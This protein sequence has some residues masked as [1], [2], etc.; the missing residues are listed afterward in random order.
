MQTAP[1]N[2]NY[3]NPQQTWGQVPRGAQGYYPGPPNGWM[4][5]PGWGA[6]QTCSVGSNTSTSHTGFAPTKS[7][8][9]FHNA[10]PTH[11]KLAI[12]NVLVVGGPLEPNSQVPG[13]RVNEVQLSPSRY[14]HLEE[15]RCRRA[16]K[17]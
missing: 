6:P 3:N 1:S 9:P 13:E 15:R 2:W 12:P 17:Q 16:A 8:G 10:P 7:S 14:D 11:T 5:Q 4:P